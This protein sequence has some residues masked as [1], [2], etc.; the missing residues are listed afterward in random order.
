[1]ASFGRVS[2]AQAGSS[3]CSSSLPCAA[4]HSPSCSPRQVNETFEGG[5]HKGQLT[6]IGQQQAL[7]LGRWLRWRYAM[8]HRLLP[9]DGFEATTVMARTTNYQRTIATLQVR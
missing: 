5:C 2:S 1:M 4:L 3:C 6:L 9:V 7:D 8:V